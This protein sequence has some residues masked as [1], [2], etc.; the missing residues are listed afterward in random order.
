[1]KVLEDLVVEYDFSVR[2]SE[3]KLI[4]FSF[5]DDA[6]D[7]KDVESDE[8]PIRLAN[9]SILL[10]NFK[11]K[12]EQYGELEEVATKMNHD[13]LMARGH[14][15]GKKEGSGNGFS[16]E[17]IGGA[18]AGGIR[19]IFDTQFY[20]R[21]ALMYPVHR[22][23]LKFHKVVDQLVAYLESQALKTPIS[24]SR[25]QRLVTRIIDKIVR[26]I[27]N[28]GEAV[29]AIAATSLGEPCTQMTLKTFHFA[30]VA[31]MNVTLGV[32][33]IKEIFN[34][35]EDIATPIIE[36]FLNNP[37]EGIPANFVKNRINAVYLSDILTSVEEVFD[38][39]QV[40]LVLKFDFQVISSALVDVG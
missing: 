20:P 40:Y 32:P 19:E 6:F 29:G 4:Q 39:S 11:V 23:N 21:L 8:F 13:F 26:T 12:E 2:N 24:V 3:K 30:G 18:E 15:N 27:V 25:I 7:P 9:N 14:T 1:M 5:G 33:R 22:K 35:A 38:R 16:E 31:S 17:K 28:P 10:K 36:I 37:F 34:A